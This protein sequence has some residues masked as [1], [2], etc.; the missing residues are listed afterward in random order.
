MTFNEDTAEAARILAGRILHTHAK[1]GRL[2]RFCHPDILY[3][4]PGAQTLDRPER[5]YCEE[6]PL[7]QGDVNFPLYLR[8]LSETGY[9][10]YL[11]IERETGANPAEDIRQA[12]EFLRLETAKIIT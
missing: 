8:A 5:K 4:M 9:D 2:Y 3:G 11:T 7:G 12:I 10:G 1:D 6:L